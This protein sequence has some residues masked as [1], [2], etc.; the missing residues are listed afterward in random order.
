MAG[1][2]HTQSLEPSGQV[3]WVKCKVVKTAG[4]NL[5]SHID[6]HAPVDQEMENKKS[7]NVHLITALTKLSPHHSTVVEAANS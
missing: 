7:I 6:C 4:S 2:R 3:A 5:S 1:R